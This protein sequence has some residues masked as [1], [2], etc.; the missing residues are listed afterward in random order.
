MRAG[1]RGIP[2]LVVVTGAARSIGRAI[3]DAL[4]DEGDQVLGIDR[5]EAEGIIGLD[6]ARRDA[7][8]AL[9]AHTEGREVDAAAVFHSGSVEATDAE[10]WDRYRVAFKSGHPQFVCHGL[11][12]LHRLKGSD[13]GIEEALCSNRQRAGG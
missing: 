7:G 10:V 3:A 11:T 5:V 4:R 2:R 12:E 13:R 9:L 8:E 6:L 1:Q